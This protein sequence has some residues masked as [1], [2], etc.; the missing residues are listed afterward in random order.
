MVALSLAVARAGHT[1][2]HAPTLL[3]IDE[4]LQVFD[5]F[6]KSL[7]LEELGRVDR[8]QSL[9]TLPDLDRH[10]RWSG[11]SVAHVLIAETLS[12][13]RGEGCPEPSWEAIRRCEEQ[14]RSVRE[15]VAL[16]R[17]VGF[18]NAVGPS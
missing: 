10:V 14:G 16:L 9:A 8:F 2:S 12:R 18:G 17:D 7:I 5:P 13:I 4:V 11:W 6:N 15:H 1:S 3:V